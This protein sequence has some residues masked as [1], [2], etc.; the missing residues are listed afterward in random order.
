MR[1]FKIVVVVTFYAF[2]PCIYVVNFDQ[3]ITII[4]VALVK[5]ST[6]PNIYEMFFTMPVS[7]YFWIFSLSHLEVENKKKKRTFGICRLFSS[8]HLHHC[9]KPFVFVH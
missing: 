8:D 9:M 6:L 4:L 3:Y 7:F 2:S 1:F 5:G